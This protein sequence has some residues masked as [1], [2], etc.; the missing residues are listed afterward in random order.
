MPENRLLPFE[1]KDLHKNWNSKR[2]SFQRKIFI[3]Q[4]LDGEKYADKKN[5]KAAGIAEN[6]GC[7]LLRY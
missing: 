7:V 3:W 6:I 2:I 4:S 1:R 5:E